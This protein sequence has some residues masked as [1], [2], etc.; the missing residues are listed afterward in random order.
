MN[1]GIR[2]AE[3]VERHIRWL[4][5]TG[6]RTSI[7]RAEQRATESYCASIAHSAFWLL[8]FVDYCFKTLELHQNAD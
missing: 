4:R 5:M 3:L 7:N 6:Q 2:V 1:K 8:N